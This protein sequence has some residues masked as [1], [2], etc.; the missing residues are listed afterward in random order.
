MISYI[1]SSLPVFAFVIL[2]VI[3]V[4]GG[5][6]LYALR[7]KGDVFAELLIGKTAFRF[8]AKDKRNTSRLP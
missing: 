2:T 3:I 1:T 5:L 8:D 6:V 7:I 4:F